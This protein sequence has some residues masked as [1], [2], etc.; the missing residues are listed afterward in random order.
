MFAKDI[1]T[2]LESSDDVIS[3]KKYWLFNN[4]VNYFI[5]VQDLRDVDDL[6]PQPHPITEEDESEDFVPV[7][8]SGIIKRSLSLA[9]SATPQGSGPYRLDKNFRYIV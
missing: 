6:P 4:K 9:V 1:E 8:L 2:N 5:F 3:L 7:E